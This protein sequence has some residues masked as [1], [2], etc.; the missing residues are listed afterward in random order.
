MCMI[1]VIDPA[2][3]EPASSFS[4]SAFE[5][6]DEVFETTSLYRPGFMDITEPDISYERVE[7]FERFSTAGT[8]ILSQYQNVDLIPPA[9]ITDLR[10]KGYSVENRTVTLEWTSVGDNM[11][12]GRGK[13]WFSL[14][15]FAASHLK[16]ITGVH[17]GMR[18][19]L[20]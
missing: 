17:I 6:V 10:V 18:K 4:L 15:M 20:P 3:G 8:L 12:D 9:Q 14:Q 2:F 16:L 19:I 11:F 1:S 7:E 13:N 5:Q